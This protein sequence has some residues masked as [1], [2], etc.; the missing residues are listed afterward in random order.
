M[1]PLA[2]LPIFLPEDSQQQTGSFL[3]PSIRKIDDSPIDSPNA[4]MSVSFQHQ[5]TGEIKGEWNEPLSYGSVTTYVYTIQLAEV[6]TE[7]ESEDE[8]DDES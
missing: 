3:A 8:T 1:V 6:V 5:S 4:R 7:E 2:E